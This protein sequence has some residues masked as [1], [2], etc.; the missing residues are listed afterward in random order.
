MFPFVLFKYLLMSLSDNLQQILEETLNSFLA[1]ESNLGSSLGFSTDISFNNTTL[2]NAYQQLSTIPGIGL[3]STERLESLLRGEPL[4]LVINPTISES[5]LPSNLESLDSS[6]GSVLRLDS[7]EGS[8]LRLDQ[9]ENAS[10]PDLIPITEEPSV[11]PESRSNLTSPNSD[12]IQDTRRRLRLWSDLLMDYHTQMTHYQKNVQSILQ[13][14]ETML[15][16]T[17]PTSRENGLSPSQNWANRFLQLLQN[18][19]PNNSFVLEFDPVIL[20]NTPPSIRSRGYPSTSPENHTRLTAFQIQSQTSIFTYDSQ[21][22]P[23]TITICPITLEEFQEGE[24]LMRIHHCGH[25]FKASELHRWLERNHK[26]PSCRYD[27]TS[28]N[29]VASS[30]TS[31]NNPLSVGI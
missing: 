4:Q 12:E 8:V 19:N 11:V 29:P 24:M 15:P 1:G 10:L 31:T 16:I 7:S 14:T 18:P 2:L 30:S 22:N 23:L 6:E 20:S 17:R 3:N 9:E 26:C 27:L 5:Q 25:I 21:N 28:R 13:I